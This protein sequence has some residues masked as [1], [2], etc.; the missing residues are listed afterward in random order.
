MS[1]PARLA[2]LVLAAF[3]PGCGVGGSPSGGDTILTQTPVEQ[4]GRMLRTYQKGLKPPGKG[5]KDRDLPVYRPGPVP[6]PRG[7][8]DLAPLAKG[9]PH[10]VRAIR[11]HEVL[12]FWKTDLADDPDAAGTVL[13]YARAVPDSGGQVLLRD[14]TTRTMTPDQ[15]RAARKP[16]GASTDE[17]AGLPAARA[18]K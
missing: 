12:L 1:L 17:A 11:D 3:L 16:E 9:Y 15:F 7:P 8:K 4:V 6:P 10:A 2:P 18:K 13:A 5:A 14:G